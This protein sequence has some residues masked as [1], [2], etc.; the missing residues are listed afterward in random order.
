[1]IATQ[2][3][4][5]CCVISSLP[6]LPPLIYLLNEDFVLDSRKKVEYQKI[7]G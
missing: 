4:Q 3:N 5:S 7:A 2:R 1:M 6:S